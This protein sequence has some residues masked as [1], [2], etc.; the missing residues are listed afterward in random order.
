M[1]ISP[2]SSL[3]AVNVDTV[4]GSIE[5]LLAGRGLGQFS[6]AASLWVFFAACG[7]A[8]LAI[9]FAVCTPLERFWPLTSWPKRNPIAADVTYAFFVRI[10][11]FPL[12][13]YFEF[14]WLRQALDGFLHVHGIVPPSLPGLIPAFASWPAA[15]F[16]VNFAILDL[17]DYWRHRVSHRIGWWYGI[18][19]LHHAEEQLTFWS[20]DRS[21]VLEDAI[22]Y[23]WL[24]SVGLA[25]GVPGMQFPFLILCFRFLGSIS[26]ANTR[27]GYGW[28]GEHI[29]IS[30]QFHRTHHALRAAGRRSCNFGTTLSLWDIAFRTARFRDNTVETGDAGAEPA[31]V[32]G[33]WGEQQLAGF[34]RMIR[35]ARR[36]KKAPA[37]RG[38]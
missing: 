1:W 14:N 5:S 31:L 16:C 21:H 38:A 8:E 33:P 25:I 4:R 2:T 32:N 22:T 10:V 7:V 29:F 20:D 9:S 12:I 17:A 23:V 11:L 27:V 6:H 24:M 19:S 34:R 3:I 26:H 13:A 15:V 36:G 35:L 18:H 37:M 30:P 28:L